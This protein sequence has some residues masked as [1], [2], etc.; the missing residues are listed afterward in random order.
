MPLDLVSGVEV[1]ARTTRSPRSNRACS[2]TVSTGQD[3]AATASA[4]QRITTGANPRP[5]SRRPRRA[6]PH[7]PACRDRRAGVSR[8]AGRHSTQRPKNILQRPTTTKKQVTK[9]STQSTTTNKPSTINNKH[10]ST[11]KKHT[12]TTNIAHQQTQIPYQ[13]TN[14]PQ[15]PTYTP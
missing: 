15:Q 2:S 5:G 14:N 9:I 1:S 13:L 11:T 4:V 8:R 6:P 3:G 10:A 12:T 7:R